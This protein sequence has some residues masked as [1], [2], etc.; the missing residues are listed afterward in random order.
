MCVFLLESIGNFFF[1]VYIFSQLITMAFSAFVVLI[2]SHLCLFSLYLKDVQGSKGA[3]C[4]K[5]QCNFLR[6]V[7][8][9]TQTETDIFHFMYFHIIAN[10]KPYLPNAH[11]ERSG[12]SKSLYIP[13]DGT[14]E[15]GNMTEYKH[16]SNNNQMKDKMVSHTI[17]NML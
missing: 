2:P 3:G 5:I 12:L 11:T 13:F 8:A 4:M 9:C 14:P 16:N 10:V 7:Y 6:I 15:G 1:F 17:W